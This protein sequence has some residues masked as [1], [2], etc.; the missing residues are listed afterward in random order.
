MFSWDG[1][2]SYWICEPC[3]S[4]SPALREIEPLGLWKIG[5]VITSGA[6]FSFTT[7]V[8]EIL[9]G[10]CGGRWMIT[11]SAPVSVLSVVEGATRSVAHLILFDNGTTRLPSAGQSKT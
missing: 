8:E 4:A 11:P 6:P 10:A 7:T 5:S 9:S 1:P 2:D 3:K